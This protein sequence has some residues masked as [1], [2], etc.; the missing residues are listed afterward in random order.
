MSATEAYCDVA[1]HRLHAL[2][3]EPVV[4]F[5]SLAGFTERRL[6]PAAKTCQSF[7]ARIESLARR[8]ERATAQLRTRVEVRIHNQNNQ[9][10]ASMNDNARRQLQLQRLVEGLSVVGM[11]YY[12]IG[13]LAYMVKGID[14]KISGIDTNQGMA[15]ATPIIIGLCWLYLRHRITKMNCRESL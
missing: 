11:S 15:L 9:I 12:L 2:A 13:L 4:G 6:L 5:Q 10:L 7:S 14:L 3:A 8:I 1:L